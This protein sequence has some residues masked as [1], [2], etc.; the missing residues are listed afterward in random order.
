MTVRTAR[1]AE[2]IFFFSFSQKG[3]LLESQYFIIVIIIIIIG[4]CPSFFA[5]SLRFGFSLEPA[6]VRAAFV[7]VAAGEE[8]APLRRGRPGT[9]RGSAGRNAN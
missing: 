2:A 1:K 3:I 6:A 9:G 7:Q 4:L 8:V 5:V